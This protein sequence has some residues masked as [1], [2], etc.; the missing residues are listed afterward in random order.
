MSPTNSGKTQYFV[1]QLRGPFPGKFD[2]MILICPTFV[3]AKTYERFVDHD[4]SIF[5]VDCPQEE[6]E[7]WRKLSRSFCREQTRLLFWTIALPRRTPCRHKRWGSDA[8]D[9]QRCKTLSWRRGRH[10]SVLLS[11]GQN[12]GNHLWRLRWRAFLWRVQGTDEWAE[13]CPVPTVSNFKIQ[14][15][16]HRPW[17]LRKNKRWTKSCKC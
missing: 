13:K 14:N 4:W 1:N 10:C 2:D 3:H 8:A 15:F 7:L 6:V 9:H 12:H 17:L 11:V 16:L 5:V